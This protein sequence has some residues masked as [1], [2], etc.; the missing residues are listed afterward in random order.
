METKR[1][2]IRDGEN[3]DKEGGGARGSG[4]GARR[5]GGIHLCKRLVHLRGT[6]CDHGGVRD[7]FVAKSSVLTRE[8]RHFSTVKLSQGV[9]E[10]EISL[11]RAAGSPGTGVN[12]R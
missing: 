1:K 9:C 2:T 7:D 10:A 6:A 12:T 5:V 4:G 8:Q 3:R 11:L